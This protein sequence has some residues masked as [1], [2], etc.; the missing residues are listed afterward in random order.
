MKIEHIALSVNNT[1]EIKNFYSNILGMK[2]VKSFVLNKKLA[3]SIF[4]I[5]KE[6]TVFLLQKDKLFFEIFITD[7]QNNQSYNHIC[8]A[9]QN[10]EM[11]VEK[12]IK[13]GYMCVRIEREMFD[14]IFIKDK[15]GNIFEIKE[16][17]MKN[18]KI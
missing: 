13:Q 3:N 17:N 12:A 15:S 4:K 11:L 1:E 10:R 7:R 16:S 14:L 9:I 2:K 5:E 8:I 18:N 6:A